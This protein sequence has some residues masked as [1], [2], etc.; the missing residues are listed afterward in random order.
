MEVLHNTFPRKVLCN[1]FPRKVLC[2]GFVDNPAGGRS[3]SYMRVIFL[4]SIPTDPTN[5]R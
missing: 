4:G 5:V 2:M 1:T 3:A